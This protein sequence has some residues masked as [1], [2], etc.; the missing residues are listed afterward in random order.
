M[1]RMGLLKGMQAQTL[2][3]AQQEH[4]TGGSPKAIPGWVI[5]LSRRL[6]L[7]QPRLDGSGRTT[8]SGCTHAERPQ[9]QNAEHEQQQP[10]TSI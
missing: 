3:G 10:A 9:S 8:E 4:R 6:A 2:R 5:G 7:R 1:V